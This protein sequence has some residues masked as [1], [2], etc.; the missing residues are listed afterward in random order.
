MPE[1]KYTISPHSSEFGPSPRWVRVYF[2]G[3]M[4]A[5][6]KSMMLLREK[7]HLPVY[8][9]PKQDVRMDFLQPSDH[10]THSDYK[11]DGVF[12]H[13]QVDNKIAN[14]AAFIFHSSSGTGLK[15]EDYVAFEWNKMD[16]W[17][18]E[19][20]EIFVYARD[21][22]KRVD[23]IQSSRHIK[24][25]HN[26]I[27]LG[28]TKRPT[29][30]FE[31]GLPTRYYMPKHDAHMDL[32]QR[33]DTVS[34]CPYKGEANIYTVKIDDSQNEGLAWIYRFPTLECTKIQGLVGFFNE[35]LD[36][37]EDGILLPRPKTVWS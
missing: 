13:V 17:F 11:G 26:G 27:T 36:I 34:R 14:N 29:L 8:Y 23:V 33:T 30:L 19:D 9:F 21:P 31:T 1:T 4:I 12:W 32:L 25:V 2:N 16:A 22:H 10:K 35:K 20:E 6:S 15:L 5:G 24:V 18:E 37:Y 3:Q 7:D 28:E